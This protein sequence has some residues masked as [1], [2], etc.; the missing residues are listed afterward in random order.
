MRKYLILSLA[1]VLATTAC[2]RTYRAVGDTHLTVFD[3]AHVQFLPDSL[4][5]FT[6]A[7]AEGIVPVP[8]GQ[9][10]RLHRRRRGRH[11]PP[12]ERAD[13]PQEGPGA[14]L[15]AE[16]G[17]E[18][19]RPRGIRRRPLGQVRLR[20]RHSR[21]RAQS[22]HPVRRQGRG[23]LA[24]GRFHPLREFRGPT[25]SPRWNSCAS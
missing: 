19:H 7:D 1:A 11:R 8:A 25:S 14:R 22:E 17:R 20:V 12:H 16:S 18:T 21:E 13:H 10:G 9:P 5:G 24:G 15:Q 4:G 23:R 2:T 3:H 6:D